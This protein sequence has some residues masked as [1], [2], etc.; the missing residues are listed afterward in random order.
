LYDSEESSGKA[1]FV[2][3]AGAEFHWIS[4]RIQIGSSETERNLEKAVKEV[5]DHRLRRA[6]AR[7]P[8]ASSLARRLLRFFE[9]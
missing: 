4:L 2:A 7:L 6:Q 5:D 8:S 3:G 9:Y 1:G